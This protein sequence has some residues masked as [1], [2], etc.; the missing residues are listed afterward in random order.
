[1]C[2]TV[3]ETS[4][5]VQLF[6]C[7][8]NKRCLDFDMK[9]I[10]FAFY[11]IYM[12]RFMVISLLFVIIRKRSQYTLIKYVLRWNFLGYKTSIMTRSFLE[13]VSFVV[14]GSVTHIWSDS[15]KKHMEAGISRAP[16]W[17]IKQVDRRL[18]NKLKKNCALSVPF[19]SIRQSPSKSGTILTWLIALFQLYKN[20]FSFGVVIP[21]C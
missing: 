5:L 4:W 12:L 19:L 18:P 9:F 10:K 7:V 21:M 14:R 3:Y 1:M 17:K 8:L 2:L 15:Y 11:A 6:T 20:I 16:F 13:S